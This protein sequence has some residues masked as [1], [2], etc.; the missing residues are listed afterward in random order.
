MK[1]INLLF[2]S[3]VALGLTACGNQN[4]NPYANGYNGI[5]GNQT[6][7][8][9]VYQGGCVPLQSGGFGFTA[10]GAQMNGAIILAGTLPANSTRPGTYGQVAMGSQQMANQQGM[11]QYQPKI[12][13]SGQMQIVVNPSGGTMSGSIQ[14]SQSIVYQLMSMQTGFNTG[15]NNQAQNQLCIQTVALD[16]V[17]TAN[18]GFNG[19]FGMSTG[20]INQALVYLTLNNGQTIGPIPFY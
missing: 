16:I 20:Y 10:Q 11:I 7:Y 14:L 15:F 6:G 9:G 18:V 12:S 5:Y 4:N 17:H 8:N 19:G 1:T 2:I 13:S 3:I